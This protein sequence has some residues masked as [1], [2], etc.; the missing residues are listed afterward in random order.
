[1]ISRKAV[2]H[3]EVYGE[4]LHLTWEGT[5]DTLIAYD[6]ENK[7]D[8]SL[9]VDTQIEHVEG[10]SNLIDE[11]PYREEVNAFLSTIEIGKKPLWNFEKDLLLL[12]AI[13]EIEK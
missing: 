6:I 4:D 5:P 1:M 8:M 11:N 3:F 7:V 13:D 12:K 9:L 10:Y 2:R